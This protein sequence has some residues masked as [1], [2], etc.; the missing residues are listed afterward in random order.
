MNQI[1]KLLKFNFSRS[2]IRINGVFTKLRYYVICSILVISAKE[3][4]LFKKIRNHSKFRNFSWCFGNFVFP[5]F[6]PQHFWIYLTEIGLNNITKHTVMM[7]HFWSWCS[8]SILAKRTDLN[9][10]RVFWETLCS[11]EVSSQ[12][13]DQKLLYWI[14]AVWPLVRSVIL[15]TCQL[16]R[17]LDMWNYCTVDSPLDSSKLVIDAILRIESALSSLVDIS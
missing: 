16:Q 13:F 7:R 12:I 14:T 3:Y 10:V 4:N 15:Y 6:G 17:I 8:T 5:V 2:F 11:S 9:V 1:E